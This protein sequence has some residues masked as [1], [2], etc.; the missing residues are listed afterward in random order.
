MAE[1]ERKKLFFETLKSLSD[2][3][4]LKPKFLWIKSMVSFTFSFYSTLKKSGPGNLL[5][6]FNGA[7][8]IM[9]NKVNCVLVSLYPVNHGLQR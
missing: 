2:L 9:N 8:K 5:I 6:I 4:T 1:L 3:I 7:S